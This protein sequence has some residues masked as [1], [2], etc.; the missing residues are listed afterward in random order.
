MSNTVSFI[1]QLK[2][3]FS[4]AARQINT[5]FRD[6]ERN[7]RRTNRALEAQAKRWKGIGTQAKK[8]AAATAIAGAVFAVDVKKLVSS[9]SAMENA[10]SD[11]GRVTTASKWQLAAFENRLESLSE[12]LGKTNR[13]MERN[14]RTTNRVLE[15]QAKRWKDIVKQA[16]KAAAATAIAGAV[17][18]VAVKELVRR[19]SAMEDA[20]SDVGRVTTASKGQLA[21]FENRL[22]S[23]SEKLGKT[24]LGLAQMAFEG[25][26]M[27]V[28]LPDMEPFIVMV[29]KTAT[30]FD[31]M[32]SEA[33]RVIGSI[34]AKMKLA[35]GETVR[36]LDSVNFLADSTTANGARMVEVLERTSGTMALLKV[37]PEAAAAFAGFADQIE[38]TGELAASGLNMF[39]SR[40][41]KM[42]GMTTK[43]MNDPLAT[44][45]ETL[46]SISKMGPEIQ[47]KFITKAFGEEAGR[48]VKKMV[49]NFELFDKTVAASL[50][51]GAIGS[52]DREFK[53]QMDRSSKV[54]QK[55]SST[56]ANTFE[57]IGDAIKPI[58][59]RLAE[60]FTPIIDGFGELV[61]NNPKLVQIT[62]LIIGAAIA[63]GA[64]SVAAIGLAFVAAMI[65]LPFIAI[66]LL[67]AAVAM[68][69]IHWKDVVGG[70]KLLWADFSNMVAG[71]ADFVS[72]KFSSMWDGMKPSLVS[73]VN[74]A[75]GK[76][77]SLLAP[78][79]FVSK[80]L[81]FGGVGI[82]LIGSETLTS[83]QAPSAP[84]YHQNGIINGAITVSAEKGTSVRSIRAR[85]RGA[86]KNIGLNMV[87]Q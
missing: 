43:L 8:A 64:L 63:V 80:K 72:E 35:R 83:V 16:K 58:A 55:F 27:G 74:F 85:N 78:L 36:L 67:I 10:I 79:D 25:G 62:T 30:A 86:A 39:M 40:M 17:F 71:V 59:V 3:Q 37:P 26:K 41:Q 38:V 29:S 68:L 81:G 5:S 24:K 69:W 51:K 57:N 46:E 22:E 56:T 33:G 4:G 21:A 18:A 34:Q 66:T 52:I 53:N 48:F 47:S 45:R 76:I 32:D 1:I 65:S 9:S 23:L 7:A 2:N 14:A 13:D 75:I 49:S 31:L 12:K 77:N 6:M 60:A 82:K 84:T 73:F 42:P 19:S 61:K 44:V 54:F 11:V 28:N 50:S 15:A 20:I 87:T 70:A